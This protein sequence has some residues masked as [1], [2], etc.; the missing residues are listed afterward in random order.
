M[1]RLFI[2]SRELNLISDITKEVIKDVI[3]QKVFYYK[4]RRELSNVHDVYQESQNK[5]FD[6]PIELDALV[7]WQ[8]M[9]QRTN[10]FGSELYSSVTVNIH[11]RDILD[12]NVVVKEG[13]FFSYGSTFYEVTSV[14]PMSKIF[15]QIEHTTGLKLTG[16]QAREG[17][18]NKFPL[19]PTSEAFT[20][21]DA[22]QDTF[23]QQRGFS[24]NAQGE[25]NDVR[26]LRK[27]GVLQDPVT[28]PKEVLPDG[29]SSSFYGDK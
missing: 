29:V 8:P 6:P 18:I 4:V 5:V 24:V 23:V 10:N 14:I 9:E 16:K 11:Q 7:E 12:K 22:V 20:E 15:G 13:D 17:I 19:G 1:A 27:N 25:T 2:T 21:D 26:D 3:G 28:G